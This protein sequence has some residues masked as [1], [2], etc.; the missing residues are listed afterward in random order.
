LRR[1]MRV[2]IDFKKRDGEDYISYFIV[3]VED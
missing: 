2:K 3:P 1:G